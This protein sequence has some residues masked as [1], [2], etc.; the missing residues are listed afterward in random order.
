MFITIET[1][2][3][4]V[5]IKMYLKLILQIIFHIHI[6]FLISNSEWKQHNNWQSAGSV[7]LLEHKDKLSLAATD[8]YPLTEEPENQQE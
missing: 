7:T 4:L 3:I 1:V 5:R 2:L 8:P 6:I